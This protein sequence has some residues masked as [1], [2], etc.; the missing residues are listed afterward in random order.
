MRESKLLKSICYLLVPILIGILVLSI[1]YGLDKKGYDSKEIEDLS[2][3]NTDA[4]LNNYMTALSR[5]TENLIY[6]NDKYKHIQDG[7][8]TIYYKNTYGNGDYMYYANEYED[9]KDFY[10]VI[11]YKQ[12]VYTN[13]ELTTKT[14]TLEKL[15]SYVSKKSEK[16]KLV[17]I[18]NGNVES[19][20]EI[21]T[22]KAIQFFDNFKNT[23]Y[24]KPEIVLP[25]E[26]SQEN[27]TS[28]EQ[29]NNVKTDN[30]KENYIYITTW[31]QD[32]QIFSSYKEELM[33]DTSN[34]KVFYIN[35]LKSLE[36]YEDIMNYTIPICSVSL[37]IIAFYLVVSIGH[38]KGKK[39]IDINDFDKV[40]IEI[41]LAALAG[42]IFLAIIGIDFLFTKDIGY[43]FICSCLLTGYFILYIVLTATVVTIIKRIKAR[44][45]LR[46]S[47][48]GRIVLWVIRSSKKIFL[49]IIR[50]CQLLAESWNSSKKIIIY[51]SLYFITII[52]MII[53]FRTFGII[54]DVLITCFVLYKIIERINCLEKIEIHLKKLYE[55]IY[56]EKLESRDFTKEFQ[57]W[58]VYINNI[59]KGFEKAI[60]EGIKSERL[61]TELITN[62]SHDIK[63]PLTSIINYVDLLK[64][65]DIKNEKVKE[66]IAVLENKSQRLKKLTEDLVEA[67][68]ASSG[69]IKLDMKK[70]KL[71][72]LIKQSIGEFEDKF[73]EK[74]LEIV[75]NY[76]KQDIY[77]L[78]DNRCLY[79]VIENLFVN[80]SKYAL[81]NSRVYIDVKKEE[82]KVILTLKNI[83][84]DGLNI[85][86][87]ELTQRFVRGDK[88]RTTEGSGL[89]LSISKSL[90]E[91]QKGKF[92]LQIDGD[93]FKVRIEFNIA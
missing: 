48:I 87:D 80:I 43:Q 31:L 84:K 40:F 68:K 85:S 66:Y 6:R 23:Y 39:G 18:I 90:T 79:R 58:I 93:L 17:N 56:S 9:L 41:I 70:I 36:R 57:K 20:S 27:S 52:L 32:F 67:S 78:A 8:Y 69:N 34:E 24:T 62:V 30:S 15:K 73:K 5:E 71:T 92:D 22:M 74:N 54:I 91:I 29:T 63:T 42:C 82:K 89:G 45:F 12:K 50:S 44:N 28:S 7:D 25:E 61:K 14:N 38:S 60:K 33:T 51:M 2:Y 1:L 86:A 4:F 65:E 46:Y 55:G 13:I 3:F 35:M 72:E 76:P 16:T 83:S 19:D 59:S 21:I 81:E 37:M 64:K 75:S 53:L 26:N 77:I 11:I 47:I 10:F 49:K 88:S